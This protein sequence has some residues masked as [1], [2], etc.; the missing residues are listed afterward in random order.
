M[1]FGHAFQTSGHSIHYYCTGSVPMSVTSQVEIA[2]SSRQKIVSV[3]LKNTASAASGTW[4]PSLS[5]FVAA[6][7][8]DIVYPI[9]GLKEP[10]IT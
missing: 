10:C 2:G 4:I 7:N 3:H 8:G 1:T 6:G 9:P 5:L